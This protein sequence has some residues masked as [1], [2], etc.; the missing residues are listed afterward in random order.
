MRRR[1]RTALRDGTL[2]AG[3]DDGDRLL[4]AVEELVSNG[5]RHGRPPVQ[6]TI[7]A[8]GLGWLVE[9]RD[10]APARLPVPP[11]DRDAALGGMGLD[12]VARMSRM[13]GVSVDG[14]WKIVWAQVP[15]RTP[16]DPPA[17]RI[18]AATS[19]ARDLAACV[20]VTEAQ[21]AATLQRL[22]MDATARS[23]PEHARAYRAAAQRA[24]T[25]AERA[26]RFSRTPPAVP[27][28]HPVG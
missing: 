15:Y 1:L 26:R 8:A 10:A 20:A 18:R 3:D 4:L 2:P 21:I 13:H 6:V 14:H 12:L 24:H 11:V 22:A 16:P 27:H 28:R 19:R 23:R 25:E 5:L 17:E 9:V 7:T